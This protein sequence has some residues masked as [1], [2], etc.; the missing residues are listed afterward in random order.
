M[1]NQGSTGGTFDA[2]V[3]Y[4][5]TCVFVRCVCVDDYMTLEEGEFLNDIIIDFYLTY[6]HKQFLNKEDR[7]NIY[8]FRK[9][10]MSQLP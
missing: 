10:F 6:L 4:K 5:S 8:V 7:D 1:S 3:I 2:I 9:V